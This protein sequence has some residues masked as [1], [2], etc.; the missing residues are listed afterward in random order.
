[1]L[2]STGLAVG[3]FTLTALML[4]ML[5]AMDRHGA[6]GEAV[7]AM[8]LAVGVFSKVLDSGWPTVASLALIP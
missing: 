1:A 5:A 8:V 3:Q 2:P 7:L 4:G 6:G